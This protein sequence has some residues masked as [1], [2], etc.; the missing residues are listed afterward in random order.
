[1]TFTITKNEHF[2]SHYLIVYPSA[3]FVSLVIRRVRKEGLMVRGISITELVTGI[4]L[5]AAL[6]WAAVQL[7]SIAL[8]RWF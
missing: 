6:T 7:G 3:A 8:E 1:M 2:D 4:L 5:L